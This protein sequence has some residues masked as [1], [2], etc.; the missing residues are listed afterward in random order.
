MLCPKC[1]K[2]LIVVERNQIELDW[3]PECEGF[4]FDADEWKLLGVTN[5][6]Y[7]PFNYDA[8]F[9]KEKGRKCPVCGKIMHKIDMNGVL[10]DKCPKFHGVWFDKGELSQ[11]VNMA[12]S[13]LENFKTINFLGEVFNIS[14]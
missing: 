14:N 12:G 3:C 6:Q 5:E 13:N 8:V 11:F 2:P 1:G 7:N 10:L 4:W 9:S